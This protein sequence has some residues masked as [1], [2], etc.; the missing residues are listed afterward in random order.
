[1]SKLYIVCYNC[2]YDTYEVSYHKSKKGAYKY[3]M[4]RQYDNWMLCRYVAPGS[5]DELFFNV[6]ERELME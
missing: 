3:I 6:I 2:D 1:M 5:Y 4:K